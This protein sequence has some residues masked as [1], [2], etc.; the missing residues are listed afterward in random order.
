MKIM[1]KLIPELFK[2][3]RRKPSTMSYPATKADVADRFRGS[4]KFHAD[5]C[6]GCKL[7]MRNCPADAIE[8]IKVEDKVF[9]AVVKMDKC[10]FCGQC[11]DSCNKSALENT[12]AFELAS[13]SRESLKVEI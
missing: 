11:V 4:L 1:G 13:K 5:R 10:I 6:V 2:M 3:M 9:K 7:C 8:I 12:Q